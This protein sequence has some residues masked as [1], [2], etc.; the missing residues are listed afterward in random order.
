M[1]SMPQYYSNDS[2]PQQNHREPPHLLSSSFIQSE[3]NSPT[4]HFSNMSENDYQTTADQFEIHSH[5]SSLGQPSA[6]MSEPPPYDGNVLM[7]FFFLKKK[8]SFKKIY[9][10]IYIKKK[11]FFFFFFFRIC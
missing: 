2:T 3:L 1:G 6:P 4:Q 5:S 7:C 10:Y 8:N 9:I 11:N